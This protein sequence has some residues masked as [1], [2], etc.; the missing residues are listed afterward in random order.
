MNTTC[1]FCN[2]GPARTFFESE[3]VRG[4]WDGFPVSPDHA[5]LVTR[6]HVG[7]WFDATESEQRALTCAVE[8]ARRVILQ[9]G[10]IPDGF[11]I[12]V[13]V[14]AAAGQ[15][16]D[17]LHVHVIP[18]YFGDVQDPR[19]GV[20]YVIPARANYLS[21]Q[22][23]PAHA[24]CLVTGENDPLFPHIALQMASAKQVDI[25]VSFVLR[26]GVDRV[27]AHLF[28]LLQRGGRVR[29]LTG[30]YLGITEPDALL[31]LLDLEGNIDCRVFETAAIGPA[32]QSPAI[33]FHPKAYIFTHATGGTAFVGSSNL[34]E[35]ALTTSVEWNYRVVSS[36]GG[37]E[38][39]ELAAAFDALFRDFRTKP[40]TV[41]WIEEYRR[42]R[43][44]QK[45][46]VEAVDIE[47]EAPLPAVT[48]TAVQSAALEAL[49]NSRAGGNRAGLVVMATGL[50]K[51]WLS[52]FDTSRPEFKRVLF[53]AHREEIL[54][55]ALDTFRK[56]RPQAHLGHY[57]GQ[58]KDPMAQVI[59]ASIQTL[60][61]REHLG[62]FAPSDFDYIVV[63]EFHH[64]SAASYRKLLSYFHPR[65]L[66]GLTATPERSDGGDL[67][68]LCQQNLVYRC[69]LG[70]GIRDGFL[71]PFHYYGVPDE[72]D[73]ANIPWRSARFDE[74]ALTAAVATQRRAENA[75]EQFRKRAGKRT[76]GF[77]VSQRHADFMAVFFR[78]NGLRS[79]AVHSGPTSGPRAMSL[80]QLAAGDLDI[81]FA[82]D[83][84]NEGIDLP[85]LDTV[86][87]LRPTE[88]KILW[89]QQFGRG[90]RKAPGK[91][92]LTVIDYIGNH[93][94]F[95]LKPQTLFDL[96]PGDREMF[97]LIERLRSGEVT[98]PPGCEVTYELRT[99]EI[100]Q[101]LL[102]RN[103]NQDEALERHYEDFK[104][105]HGLRPTASEVYLD[106]YNP[107]AVRRRASSWMRFVAAQGDL[108]RQHLR[109]LEHYN[110]FIDSIETTEMT[111]SYKMLVLLAM[112]NADTFPGS[113][114]VNDLAEGVEEFASRTTKAAEDLGA[115][116]HDRRAL[117]R[118]LEQHP[119]KAWS[120]GKG[121]GG[122]P[123][124]AYA[125]GVF[126]TTLDAE[127]ETG[128]ALQEL[129]RELAEWRLT[130]Y[131][132]RAQSRTA[133]HSIL[134]VS[135]A[136]G[137]PILFLPSE[138][139]RNKL[140]QGWT[141]VLIDGKPYSANFV[142]VA[143]N[144]VRPSGSEDNVLASI[145]RRWFGPD[146]GAPGTRHS[147]SLQEN[148][149]NWELAPIGANRGSLQLWRSYSREEIPGFF[150]FEF[151]TA[152]WNK[153]FVKQPGHMFLLV[154]LDKSG[155]NST[156]QYK[157]HFVN[158]TEF[159][160]QSQ[161]RTRQSSS[162][163]QD[164]LHH[165]ER[166]YQVHLF[167]RTDRKRPR[168]GAAPFV[169]CGAVEF[170]RWH[171]E[172]PITVTWKLPT[173]L[174]DSLWVMMETSR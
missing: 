19:G 171:G 120:E 103:P 132:D 137:K 167:V 99:I 159:E 145:L 14:G 146:A 72:V 21:A 108:D 128:L 89:L 23:H 87:M 162:D 172:Q 156:F 79:V 107:R 96:G 49:Q 28:D 71:A 10:R 1:P 38:F 147:V 41:D 47:G 153:G 29:V 69:D 93:R 78:S 100:L 45:P 130:E 86:M 151:S 68:A 8:V 73:Y 170:V 59:F 165:R 18:R 166:L 2:L 32:L 5:L 116:L 131:L 84:F 105:I 40:M 66:L 16:V 64:A 168:G 121:T 22:S 20:R 39:G 122:V 112:L 81:V 133:A 160:W 9:Q 144:V 65:F 169:Y 164:I 6:R 33:S 3:L 51:T 12:G 62:R 110:T 24:R 92:Q 117:I 83:M 11:N 126:Q 53:V 141:E 80:E 173:T 4:L 36:P 50:G 54:N 63:D 102:R 56:V 90:L 43:P 57:T 75:L 31:H 118:L 13:N 155:H 119:I 113:I 142:K 91:Q 140:P 143:I 46:I 34:S 163:G 61:R 138:P 152:I 67:L 135:H 70:D 17:H 74:E 139:E 82:V 97:N 158:R 134:K 174:P 7:S 104:L 27:F 129:V 161:N 37:F 48:P 124:F 30:D 125:D 109:A 35:G 115:A 76:L 98:L 77:C 114:E 26:S 44:I 123:Y 111:K 42:R 85:A 88:S 136:N 154:T 60:S 95:L 148:L 127:P 101:S 55:Q 15:T 25:V 157:D 106:G 52:A 149:G 150:G 58:T 94:V